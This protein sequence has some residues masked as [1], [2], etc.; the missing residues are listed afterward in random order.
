MALPGPPSI[1]ELMNMVKASIRK[2]RAEQ[3]A[4]AAKQTGAGATPTRKVSSLSLVKKMASLASE[5]EDNIEYTSRT[6]DQ[7]V[8]T[9][10]ICPSHRDYMIIGTYSLLKKDDTCA[11]TGQ[12][13]RGSLQVM[14]VTPTFIPKYAGMLPPSLDRVDFPCAVLDMHFHPSDSTLLGVATSNAAVHFFR[15]IIHGD[16]LGRRVVTKLLPLGS[17]IV[18]E[19]DEHG[20]VPL[21]T[22]FTWFPETRKHGVVGISDVTDVGFAATTSFGDTKVVRLSVPAVKDLFDQRADLPLQQLT[23][24]LNEAV[25]KH[26]LEAWTVAVVDFGRASSSSSAAAGENRSSSSSSN[27]RMILSGG[28]DSALIAS[29]IP[30]TTTATSPSAPTS[31]SPSSYDTTP[32]IAT[33]LWK[34]RRSHAAGVVAILPLSPVTEDMKYTIPLITGSYDEFIRVFEID[35]TTSRASFKTELR[36][37]GGV[38]RL[39]VLD[40]YYSTTSNEGGQVH[41]TL[42]LASLMHAGAAIV[43]ITRRLTPTAATSGSS[44]SPPGGDNTWTITPVTVFRAGHESMVYCCDARL[45]SRGSTQPTDEGGEQAQ[46]G[47]GSAECLQAPAYTIVSTSFYDM[48]ICTWRFVDTFKVHSP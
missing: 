25:H 30:A 16:V 41:H 42:I 4:Q 34:D 37:D 13:R 35:T 15:F 8:D 9:V 45:D 12:T 2:Y 29:S 14:T 7:E 26:D 40:Q 38:W 1:T 10:A 19:N 23:P 24:S 31:A 11:Y 18:S 46:R 21:V 17:V 6:A 43:R 47:S 5:E 39:K 20:L 32:P 22:Q 3:A 33:P 36:L 48:K 27:S 44:S 28:D